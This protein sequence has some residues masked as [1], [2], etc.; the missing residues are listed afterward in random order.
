LNRA[1]RIPGTH[2]DLTMSIENKLQEFKD[3]VIAEFEKLRAAL[4]NNPANSPGHAAAVQAAKESVE[5]KHDA[6]QGAP[7]PVPADPKPIGAQTTGDAL[8]PPTPAANEPAKQ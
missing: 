5:A 8:T 7:T 3:H 4:E 2:E 1:R 6:L